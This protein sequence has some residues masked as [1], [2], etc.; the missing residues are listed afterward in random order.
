MS[1]KPRIYRYYVPASLAPHGGLLATDTETVF[2]DALDAFPDDPPTPEALEELLEPVA[3]AFRH[4]IED[5]LE[6]GSN[7]IMLPFHPVSEYAYSCL[8]KHPF[9][10]VLD[11]E[12]EVG[13]TPLEDAP[14]TLYD[15]LGLSEIAQEARRLISQRLAEALDGY[16]ARVAEAIGAKLNPEDKS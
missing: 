4:K 16:M 2:L 13:F 10:I 8:D 3:E 6:E 15:A 1:T 9:V 7:M 12:G 11:D 5:A 14:R